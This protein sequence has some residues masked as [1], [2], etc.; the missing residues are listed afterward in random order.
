MVVLCGSHWTTSV[1]FRS[2]TRQVFVPTNPTP[3]AFETPAPRRRAL[4]A[5]ERSRT[6]NV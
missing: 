3:V 6:T 5:F 1:P 4:C 2:T